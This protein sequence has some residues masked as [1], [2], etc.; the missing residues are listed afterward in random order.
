[1]FRVMVLST[2]CSF[3]LLGLGAVGHALA[4]DENTWSQWRG[5][6]RDG[7]VPGTVDWPT[8]LQGDSLQLIWR[9][10]LGPSYSGPIESEELVFVTETRDQQREVV[11]A[12]RRKTGEQVW[13]ASWE[14]SM[15][16]P[17]FCQSKRGLDS[18]NSSVRWRESFC[19]RHERC[20]CL[21]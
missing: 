21:P 11:R 3:G 2:I 13:E 18:I 1:M 14:G 4:F 7:Q 17:F 8:T 5:P 12:L 19:C 9:V 16:V 20:P 15:T 6:T 10:P